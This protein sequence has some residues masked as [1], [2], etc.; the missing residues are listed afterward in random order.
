MKRVLMTLV[1]MA[2]VSLSPDVNV[3][4][5]S[6]SE[7]DQAP[8]EQVMAWADREFA[9]D[10]YKSA[11]QL[12]RKVLAAQRDNTHAL[13]RLALLLTWRGEYNEAIALYGR[14]L[15]LEP[16]SVETRLGLA[17]SLAWSE[18]YPK[19][20]AL[21][22]G[23]LKERPGD[24]SI[25][26]DKA[27]AEA[28]SGDL[29]GA[30]RTLTELLGRNPRHLKGRVLMG[31]VR[32]W[33]GDPVAAEKLFRAV[34]AEAPGNAAAEAGLCDALNTQGR[35]DEALG[36]CDK[37]LAL[38]PKNRTALA[39]RASALQSQG[40]TPEALDAIRQ[41]LEL[42]PDA[43]DAR[44]L[45]REIGGPLRPTLQLFGTTVQDTDDNDL[46]TWG[47]TYTYFLKG[48]GYVGVTFTH[49]QTDFSIDD[50]NDAPGPLASLPPA[51][52][53]ARYD[54]LRLTGGWHVSPHLS[55]YAEGGAERT[56]FPLDI[57]GA[58]GAETRSHVAGSVTFEVNAG[59]WFTLVGSGSQER[60]VGTTQAFM[61]DVGIRAATLTTTFRPHPSLRLRLTGQRARFTDDDE[62]DVD[63]GLIV[64]SEDGRENHR[65]LIAAGASWHVPMRRPSLFLNYAYRRMHYEQ[66]LDQ[67]YFDPKK[68]V[69]HVGGFDISDTIGRHVYWGG[70]FDRGVQL[71]NHGHYTDV[72]GYRLLAGVNI[73]E[74]TSVEA[75]Y[76]RSD[77]ALT[78]A[79]GF[80]STEGGVRVKV[81][82]GGTYGPASPDRGGPSKQ[83]GTSD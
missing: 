36:H 55:F 47:G 54:T 13:N 45:G 81:R 2:C 37:A 33:S 7:A 24:E 68:Y 17:T 79:A 62:F 63:S 9:R 6:G 32:Q 66:D 80:K 42:Y 3:F 78:S 73:G 20:L 34:L 28:W 48:K 29:R 49:A 15:A 72:L 10:S 74:S 18:D 51:T 44:R 64:Q 23:L 22:E 1:V 8:P 69:S 59:D 50:P 25:L 26:F 57:F 12:Y 5:Q 58:V 40:R 46:S 75:Y 41:T 60:L 27:Q 53:V 16:T 4:A 52:P 14:A 31:Q 70:G 43:R 67:G 19:A 21:Y 39:G 77:H 35:H 56:R 71:V 65:G 11:E 38:E 76:A 82:F 83:R 61:N 30:G